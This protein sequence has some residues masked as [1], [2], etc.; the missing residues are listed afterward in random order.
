VAEWIE[1]LDEFFKRQR[2]A[3]L[4]DEEIKESLAPIAEEFHTSVVGLLLEN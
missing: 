4:L 3:S 2:E 1:E